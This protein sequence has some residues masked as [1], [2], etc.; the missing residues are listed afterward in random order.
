VSTALLRRPWL[1]L[2]AAGA[3]LWA[4]QQ[5]SAGA[6]RERI[7]VGDD[8][9][10]GLRQDHRRRTGRLPTPAEEAAL[11]RAFADDEILYR[12]ALA[13]GLDRNDVVVRRRLVQNMTFLLEESSPVPEPDDATLEAHLAAHPERFAVPDRWSFEHV[14]V[15]QEDGDERAAAERARALAA[16]LAGGADAT[17][18]G[19]PFAHGRSFARQ[20][21]RE[22][23]ERFGPGFAARL[24]AQP[25]GAWSE[26]L[27]SSYGLHLVRVVEHVPAAAAQLADV[28]GAVRDD[29]VRERRAAAERDALAGLRERYEVVTGP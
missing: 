27:A 17:A 24:G 1:Q 6:E 10:Q 26:P 25:A 20:S 29:W 21:A 15:R 9:V 11:V 8:V 13:L 12:E 19:D 3:A 18:L 22:V 14:F 4:V 7:V 23:D 28:R 5:C 2:L 16:R